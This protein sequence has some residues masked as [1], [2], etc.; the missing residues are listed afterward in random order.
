MFKLFARR[1]GSRMVTVARVTT[2]FK[3][4]GRLVSTR[5]FKDLQSAR[6]H[7]LQTNYNTLFHAKLVVKHV[8]R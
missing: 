8:N 6:L 4:S 2:V 1:R 3:D 7:V 5:D